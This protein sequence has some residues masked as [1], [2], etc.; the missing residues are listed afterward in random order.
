MEMGD[1]PELDEEAAPED[2]APDETTRLKPAAS[3][4]EPPPKGPHPNLSKWSAAVLL[5]TW[6]VSQTHNPH[7]PVHSTL[8]AVLPTLAHACSA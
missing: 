7:Q 2:K 3:G 6:C 4:C 8:S 5:M 1:D